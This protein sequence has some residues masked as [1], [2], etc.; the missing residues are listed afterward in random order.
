MS[1]WHL[2]TD[3]LFHVC[4]VL[5]AASSAVFFCSC[6]HMLSWPLFLITTTHNQSLRINI[7]RL[8]HPPAS[9]SK[10]LLFFLF[11]HVLWCFSPCRSN[12]VM[13]PVLIQQCSKVSKDETNKGHQPSPPSPAWY[14]V[15]S[16]FYKGTSVKTG[17][18]DRKPCWIVGLVGPGWRPLF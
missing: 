4:C 14:S 7:V 1:R 9:E 18:L 6:F 16:S 12:R 10:S 8:F 3:C 2:W 17:W 5:S 11:S 13:S 15:L